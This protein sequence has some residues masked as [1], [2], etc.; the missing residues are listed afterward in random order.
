MVVATIVLFTGTLWLNEQIFTSSEFLRG[1]NWVYLPAGMRLLCTLLF[2]ESGAIGLL[3]AS[4]LV[5]FLYFFPND[6][7]RS[8]AGGILAAAAPYMVY[9]LAEYLFG[10][11]ATL[12]HLTP[13]RLLV[14]ALACSVASPALHYLWF[15]LHG[16][17]VHLDG[18]LVMLLGDLGGTLIVLYSIKALLWALP[19]P[20]GG[21]VSGR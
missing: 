8:L 21:Q 9:K 13:W 1:V 14:C 19:K 10:L 15:W 7:V 4:W 16:D 18:M 3:L 20:Q 17:P 11:R 6:F 2:A 5:N 12:A